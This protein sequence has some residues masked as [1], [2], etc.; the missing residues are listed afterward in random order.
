[1]NISELVL[2]NEQGK[3]KILSP[4]RVTPYC[5]ARARLNPFARRD[6]D[7]IKRQIFEKRRIRLFGRIRKRKNA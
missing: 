2:L 1:M 5:S 3:I 7:L 6:F 4:R